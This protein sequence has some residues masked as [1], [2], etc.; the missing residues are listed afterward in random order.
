MSMQHVPVIWQEG[1]C[2]VNLKRQNLM[3]SHELV[4]PSFGTWHFVELCRCAHDT[5]LRGYVCLLV[6]SRYVV[7]TE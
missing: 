6:F 4:P 7:P 1:S 2:A 5:L 3:Q